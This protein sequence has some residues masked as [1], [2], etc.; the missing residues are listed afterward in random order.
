MAIKLWQRKHGHLRPP[1]DVIH[2][3]PDSRHFPQQFR[4]RIIRWA[5]DCFHRRFPPSPFFGDDS[6]EQIRGA[7][8][9]LCH[10]LAEAYGR[11]LLVPISDLPGKVASSS[12][13][14]ADRQVPAHLGRCTDFEVLDF[15]DA[16]FQLLAQSSE[17]YAGIDL[18]VLQHATSRLNAVCEEEGIGYR[19]A[20]GELIRFDDPVAHAEAVEPA[21]KLLA[22]GT[23][24]HANSE[25]RRALECYRSGDWRDA[26]TNA[27]AAFESVLKVVTGKPSLTAGPLIAEARRQGVIP[28]YMQSSAENLEKVMNVVPAVRGQEGPHGLGEREQAADDHLARFVVT[29][30]AAFIIFIGRDRS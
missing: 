1:D 6:Q 10:Q 8:N 12:D 11:A 21:M 16:I 24:G 29:T 25:F 7:L 27:N 18:E 15:I 26:I 9:S 5:G 17:G 20:D 13:Y 4:H 19:W 28:G 3:E 2:A 14:D 23:F 30:T 22:P